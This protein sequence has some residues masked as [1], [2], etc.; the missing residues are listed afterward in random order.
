ML[1]LGCG[2]NILE[3][4]AN[5]DLAKA[6]GVIRHD[7]SSG[8]PV[9]DATASIIFS[10]HFIEH[11]TRH[12]GL[13][14]LRECYRALVPGGKLRISTPSLQKLVREYSNGQVDEWGDVSWEPGSPCAMVN[15]GL[16]SWGHQYV[17][18]EHDLKGLMEEAGFVNIRR[19]PWRQSDHEALRGLE[20]RPYHEDI[21]LEGSKGTVRQGQADKI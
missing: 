21:I 6:S 1:H 5:V 10:E 7:L 9:N 8:L 12:Q 15:E 14:L 11:L 3:G 20:C 17:Y 19:M 13:V 18:D 16:R 4:W 2:N